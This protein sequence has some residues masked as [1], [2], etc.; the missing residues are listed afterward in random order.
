MDLAKAYDRVDRKGV[1]EVMK[2]YGV[3]GRNL[4]AV[5]SFYDGYEAC[6]RVENGE[7]EL[8]KVSVGLRQVCNITVAI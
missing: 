6:V 3:G 5:K 2:E 8:I 7:N 1:W 4:E